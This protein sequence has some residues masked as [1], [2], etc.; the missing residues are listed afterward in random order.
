M[1]I[2]ERHYSVAELAELWNLGPDA[3]RRLFRD[4]PGVI[5]LGHSSKLVGRKYKRR[6]YTIR[7]PESV[8]IAVYEQLR[9][10]AFT[11]S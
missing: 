2:F 6:Y 3:I 9:K 8:A 1:A 10:T 7:I 11:R 4:V 5:A